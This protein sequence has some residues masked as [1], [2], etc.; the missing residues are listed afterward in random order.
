MNVRL[1]MTCV[2]PLAHPNAA[3]WTVP[4]SATRKMAILALHAPALLRCAHTCSLA[5]ANVASTVLDTT[6]DTNTT[7]TSDTNAADT[8]APE[9]KLQLLS[10]DM[11]REIVLVGVRKRGLQFPVRMQRLLWLLLLVPVHRH[12]CG[13]KPSRWW[14]QSVPRDKS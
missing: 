8:D 13:N 6:P 11:L 12:H 1:I 5:I 10:V 3:L 2:T 4:L 14:R 7:N 9:L